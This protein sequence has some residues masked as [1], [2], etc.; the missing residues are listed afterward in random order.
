MD[1]FILKEGYHLF[2]QY[3]PKHCNWDAM[4]WGH[5]ASCNVLFMLNNLGSKTIFIGKV[6]EDQSG[7]LLKWMKNILLH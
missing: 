7:R 1:L 3:N 2:Y 6:G 4:H 5:A